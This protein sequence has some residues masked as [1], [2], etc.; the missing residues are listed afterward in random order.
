[1]VPRR[2]SAVPVS[3]GPNAVPLYRVLGRSSFNAAAGHNA[4]LADLARVPLA[5]SLTWNGH[6][7]DCHVFGLSGTYVVNTVRKNSSGSVFYMKKRLDIF[8]FKLFFYWLK[9]QSHI[10]KAIA[11]IMSIFWKI[12]IKQNLIIHI[13]TALQLCQFISYL[14]FITM[15][16]CKTVLVTSQANNDSYTIFVW[17]WYW[18]RHRIRD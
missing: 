16:I 2:S 7:V 13:T 3:G 14:I 8:T 15:T 9:R 17:W 6:A 1:M 10:F 18:Q 11:F 5:R 4:A 12:T